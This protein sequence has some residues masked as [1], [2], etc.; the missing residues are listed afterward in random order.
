M[1]E[2]DYSDLDHEGMWNLLKLTIRN[3]II[4]SR[5]RLQQKETEFSERICEIRNSI[6]FKIPILE[7]FIEKMNSIE[8]NVIKSKEIKENNVKIDKEKEKQKKWFKERLK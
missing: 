1:N 6:I 7:E 4:A 2:L 8:N 3:E 5:N